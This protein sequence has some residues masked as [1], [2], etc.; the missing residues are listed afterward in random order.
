MHGRENKIEMTRTFSRTALKMIIA[1]AASYRR[2]ALFKI[3][4]LKVWRVQDGKI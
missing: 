3:L 1:A 2:S 4:K